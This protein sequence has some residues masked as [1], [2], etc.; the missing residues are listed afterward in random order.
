MPTETF[1]TLRKMETEFNKGPYS[2]TNLIEKHKNDCFFSNFKYFFIE[3][4][5]EC[6]CFDSLSSLDL[7]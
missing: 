6:S 3:V 5:S 4:V 7:L 2:N 1:L